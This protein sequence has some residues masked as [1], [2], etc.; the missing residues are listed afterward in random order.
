MSPLSKDDLPRYAR[1]LSLPGIG[2]EGQEKLLRAR[3]LVVGAGGLG[4]P[5]LLYLAA[6]G[7]GRIGIVDSD[8]VEAGNL[9]RQIAFTTEDIGQFKALALQKRL[10]ALNPGIQISAWPERLSSANAEE[11][12]SDFDIVVDGTDNFPTRYLINDACLLFKKTCVHA[13][14]FRYEGQLSVFN[15]LRE[16]GS[17]GPNYRDL[18]P[19]PPPEEQAPDCGEA[20]VLG[21]LTGILGALQANEVIKLI[22]GHGKTLDGSLLLLD[23]ASMQFRTIQLP[24]GKDHHI[25]QL[26]DYEAFCKTPKSPN[27]SHIPQISPKEL[28]AL[29]DQGA[30]LQLIDVR[31][32]YERQ[33]ANIG[34]EL[35]PMGQVMHSVDRIERSK[36][37]VVYCRSGRRSGD[38]IRILQEHFGFTNLINLKGGIL[39][40]SE[41]VDSGV[42][43]Y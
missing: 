39:A 5:V 10:Q 6:A 31:E 11:I 24:A 17:R 28:K 18:F 1:H 12:F 34:G 25:S 30:D 22:T 8:R 35:I 7:V 26:I 16:D 15:R 3:V 14:V 9:Q 23:S 29:L 38:I 21:A 32:P 37:V 33:I 42:A 27:M 36:Q 43:K 4:C 13:S 20:G 41:E 19:A 2:P 40:W